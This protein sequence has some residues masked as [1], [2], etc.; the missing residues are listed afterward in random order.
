MNLKKFFTNLNGEEQRTSLDQFGKEIPAQKMNEVV[1]NLLYNSSSTNANESMKY[2]TLAKKIYNWTEIKS[3]DEADLALI[4]K[5][6]E[7][8]PN[9]N[10]GAKAQILEQLKSK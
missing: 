6:V 5:C 1:A 2:Y 9:L 4:T 7:T 8:S 10:A 3:I